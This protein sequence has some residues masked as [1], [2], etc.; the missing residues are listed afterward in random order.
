M[1][2]RSVHYEIKGRRILNGVDLEVKPGNIC[3]LFGPNGGGKSTLIK[4]GAG[5]ISPKSG[6]IFIEEK[7]FTKNRRLGRYRKIAYLPQD[8]F[9]PK[10]ITVAGL[11]EKLSKR[12]R[13]EILELYSSK[14]LAQKIGLLST[15]EH[16]LLELLIVLSLGRNFLLLD[17]PFTGIE[18]LIIEKMIKLIRSERDDGTGILLTD[19][20]YRYISQIADEAYLMK[21]GQCERLDPSQLRE[22]GYLGESSAIKSNA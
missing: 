2:F 6:T 7:Q 8:A 13:M 9:L 1:L 5:L 14:L 20:Y 15:G 17:E 12:A 18:P 10:D 21:N 4:I 19:Q 3:G 16:R 22:R 11:F